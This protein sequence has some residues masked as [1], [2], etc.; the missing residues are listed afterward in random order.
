MLLLSLNIL[1]FQTVNARIEKSHSGT[2]FI[3]KI[4]L[5]ILSLKQ[6]WLNLKLVTKKSFKVNRTDIKQV[7][8][9]ESSSSV[10]YL[11][12][13]RL[14]VLQKLVAAQTLCSNAETVRIFPSLTK[15]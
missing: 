11:Q 9:L 1:A 13:L 14:T 12:G 4:Y 7:L 5:I 6:C 10:I 3:R 8:T 2:E 15:D